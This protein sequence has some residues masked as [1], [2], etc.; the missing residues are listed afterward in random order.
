MTDFKVGIV[1]HYYDKI[2]VAVVAFTSDVN[3]GEKIKFERGGEELFEQ[4]L[5]S[6]QYEHQKIEHAKKGDIVG[7][8]VDKA[9][10]EGAEIFKIN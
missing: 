2:G 8:K 5:S 6:M 7:L 1:K 4:E 10:K 3:V 9:V